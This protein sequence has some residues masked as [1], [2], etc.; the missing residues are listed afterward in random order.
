MGPYTIL[1][2]VFRHNKDS[3]QVY[4]L[5]SYG[6]SCVAVVTVYTSAPLRFTEYSHQWNCL[7]AWVAMTLSRIKGWDYVSVDNCCIIDGVYRDEREQLSRLVYFFF[8]P[9]II[10][11]HP[12]SFP[13]SHFVFVYPT[14]YHSSSFTHVT[15]NQI[16]FVQWKSSQVTWQTH[17]VSPWRASGELAVFEWT[18]V[19]Q[20]K[21]KLKWPVVSADLITSISFQE[22]NKINT[23]INICIRLLEFTDYSSQK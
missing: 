9:F 1:V 20:T 23:V 11:L 3:F 15:S 5:L 21:G 13:F 19:L 7:C 22:A 16:H 6:M 8:H 2:I 12:P 4:Q 17:Q 14:M 18:L 10:Y